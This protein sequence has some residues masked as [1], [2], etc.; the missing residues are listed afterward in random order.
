MAAPPAAP[1]PPPPSPTPDPTPDPGVAG[2]RATCQLADFQAEVLTR[3]N[4]YRR[5]GATCGDRGPFAA[6][7][8]LA[9][10]PALAAAALVHS[11]DMV[12]GNFFS[13]TG[14]DGRN[15]GQRITA[16]GYAWSTWGENIAAG[17]PTVAAVV[18]AWMASPGH[19]VNLMNE[20]LRDIGVAC[21]AGGAGNTYRTYWT[22]K[23]A[24]A[25]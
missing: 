3:V 19:C 14:S 9:W 4:A 22:M 10:S 2:S 18:D 21:V 17:Q 1:T 12:A 16:A 25:R 20:R 23:L 24:T 8:G 15:A 6:T 7:G 11:D 5:A 13:H